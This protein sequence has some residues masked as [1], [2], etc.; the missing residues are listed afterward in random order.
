MEKTLSALDKV[1]SIEVLAL[2]AESKNMSF[3]ERFPLTLR[4]EQLKPPASL[5][6]VFTGGLDRS[7]LCSDA[8][9]GECC[10]F[11]QLLN[12]HRQ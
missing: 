10:S 4:G 7:I 1:C 2:P 3:L 6:H 11:Q 5:S 9:G 8:G 12:Q